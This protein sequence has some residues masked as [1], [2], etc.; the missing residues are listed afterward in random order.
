LLFNS[1]GRKFVFADGKEGTGYLL[2]Q[3]HLGGIGGQLATTSGCE[4]WGGMAY[5]AGV[6]Y[7]P[8]ISGLSAYRIVRTPDLRRIWQNTGV[9][10]GAA[11]VVGGGAVWGVDTGRLYQINPSDGSTVTSIAVGTCPHFATP[12]L[13]RSLVLVGTMNGVAAVRTD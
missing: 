5:H 7:V 11:P 9:G 13:H 2:H 8:C 12:T 3:N 10:Y 1:F 4:S 6:V